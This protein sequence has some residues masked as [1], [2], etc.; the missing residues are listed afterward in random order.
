MYEG[1]GIGLAAPQIGEKINLLVYDVSKN[2]DQ[3]YIMINPEIVDQSNE[4]SSLEEACLSLPG[5][6]AKVRRPNRV[7]VKHYDKSWN[8]QTIWF[9]GLEGR[10]IQHEIDHLH[11]VVYIDK[12]GALKNT[13][14]QKYLKSRRK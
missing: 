5:V 9:D 12:I 10:C 6:S 14:L 1:K 4:T 2:K 3:P 7:Q 11:G 8:Q 13:V